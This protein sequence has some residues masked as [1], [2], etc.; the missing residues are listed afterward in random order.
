MPADRRFR[1]SWWILVF[2]VLGYPGPATAVPESASDAGAKRAFV[3][4]PAAV[5]EALHDAA[6]TLKQ[7]IASIR[8]RTVEAREALVLAQKAMEELKAETVAVKAL[9]V[10]QKFP[11]NRVEEVYAA[12]SAR[13]SKLAASQKQLVEEMERL[14]EDTASKLTALDLLEKELLLISAGRQPDD[15]RKELETAFESYRRLVSSEDREL[16]RL[17]EIS[18]K[19]GEFLQTEKELVEGVLPMLEKLRE[20]W[21]QEL[22]KRQ[23]HLSLKQQILEIWESVAGIPARV[24]HWSVKLARSGAV[25]RFAGS[26]PMALSGLIALVAL[27]SWSARRLKRLT[28]LKLESWK[29]RSI[30]PVSQWAIG[31][32]QE[33]VSQVYPL[34]LTLWLVLTLRTLG[35]SDTAPARLTVYGLLTLIVMGFSLGLIRVSYEVAIHREVRLLAEAPARFYRR[36][37]KL[38]VVWAL[39]GAFGLSCLAL[40]G[41]PETIR[42]LV[43][44]LYVTGLLYFVIRMTRPPRVESLLSAFPEA[45]LKAKRWTVL[46]GRARYGLIGIAVIALMAYPLGFQPLS[47]HLAG[48][49]ALSVGLLVAWMVMGF[50]GRAAIHFFLHAEDGWLGKRFPDRSELLGRLCTLAQ[51]SFD[52]LLA[53]GS[54]LGLFTLW[55][56]APA[57]LLTVLQWLR[58][59]I[60]IGS[61]QLSPLNLM[62]GCFVLYLGFWFSRFTTRVLQTRVFPRTGW[63]VGIQYTI[64]T[65]LQYVILI[66]GILMALNVLGFP[67]AN[68]A[69]IMGALGVGIGLGLQNIVSNFFSGLVLLIERPI[70][71]GDMLVIDGQWG[72]VK[73]IRIRSTVFQTYDKSVMII[74]NSELTASK[75][76][77]WTH[78]GRGSSRITLKLG[79]AYGTDISLVTRLLKEVC[80]GNARVLKDPP[81]QAL[82]VAYGESSLDFSIM[83]HVAMPEDRMP[84]THELNSAI[85]DIFRDH[86]I[87]IPFPQRDLH[88]KNW[89]R[90]LLKGEA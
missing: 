35:L 9:L 55:G 4:S 36:Q 43:R 16:A 31:V 23:E 47:L 57:S 40:L 5:T 59:G 52:V 84:A 73:Q 38:F 2:L 25:E 48:S 75:I 78:F 3:A 20:S 66:F 21:K 89:P 42:Q 1:F 22:L 44:L 10:I 27:L 81:P 53:A 72:E 24:R 65:I 56:G 62:L 88:I 70:K 41:F 71:V 85:F 45:R 79:V 50:C 82:F 30:R 7:S 26:H 12:Y 34:G 39:V 58:F 33:V 69:L 63:D 18:D 13:A 11:L 28:N 6:S 29:T 74:P 77:N 90:A 8:T 67:L 19:T 15:S 86:D 32:G 76:L 60:P 17:A 80:A 51:R 37:L 83:A 14:G 61:V 68:L 49:A 46:L 64:S 87:E 54:T